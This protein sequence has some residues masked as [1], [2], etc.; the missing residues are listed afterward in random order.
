MHHTIRI[1]IEAD[2][3]LHHQH[4][5][6]LHTHHH[7][8]HYRTGNLKEEED[9]S[10][11]RQEAVVVQKEDVNAN[12][13]RSSYQPEEGDHSRLNQVQVG[14]RSPLLP[15][16]QTLMEEAREHNLDVEEVELG[17]VDRTGSC[18]TRSLCAGDTIQVDQLVR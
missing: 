14:I 2:K 15:R 6:D 13:N 8:H 4:H 3:I 11:K 17:L 12:R 18:C 10:Y 16:V 5:R 7:H 9:Q 1:Q